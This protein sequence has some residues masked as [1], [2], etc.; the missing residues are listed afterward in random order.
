MDDI[1]IIPRDPRTQDIKI[2]SRLPKGGERGERGLPGP[3]GPQGPPGQDGQD[4]PAGPQGPPGQDGQ[5]G[6]TGPQGPPGQDGQDGATG[7]QGPPGADGQDGAQGP[8]G[9]PGADGQDGATGPQG[10]PGADGQD[11]AQGPQGEQGPPGGN[12]TS[13]GPY[14]GPANV[15]ILG[16]NRLILIDPLN[17]LVTLNFPP[18]ADGDVLEVKAISTGTFPGTNVLIVTNGTDNIEDP[19]LPGTALG[20]LTQ[21]NFVGGILNEA[22]R[23][24]FTDKI[25]TSG[26][27]VVTADYEPP[28]A[29]GGGL[30]SQPTVIG[31]NTATYLQ[32]NILVPIDPENGVVTL[33]FP[34]GNDGDI[35]KVTAV[36]D[37][38][39]PGTNVVINTDGT[40]AISN[41]LTPS[42]PISSSLVA[43]FAGGILKEGYE[44]VFAATVGANGTW[45]ATSDYEPA[46]TIPNQSF[47]IT[48]EYVVEDGY[49]VTPDQVISV[50]PTSGNVIPGYTFGGST[51][52]PSDLSDL[53]RYFT[54]DPVNNIAVG[55]TGEYSVLI[56]MNSD[57]VTRPI[58]GTPWLFT[59]LNAGDRAVDGLALSNDT[60]VI[61]FIDSNS[62]NYRAVSIRTN[63]G[64]ITHP[65]N[66]QSTP[67]AV[68]TTGSVI[69]TGP[70]TLS[71]GAIPNSGEFVMGFTTNGSPNGGRDFVMQRFTSAV[72]PTPP[73]LNSFPSQVVFTT[74]GGSTF[75]RGEAIF[76]PSDK[77][78][79]LLR[80]RDGATTEIFYVQRIASTFTLLDTQSVDFTA[81]AEFSRLLAVSSGIAVVVGN[82]SGRYKTYD[83]AG[84]VLTEAVVQDPIFNLPLGD[85]LT[86]SVDISFLRGT[87]N[88]VAV[89]TINDNTAGIVY[90]AVSGTSVNWGTPI[91]NDLPKVDYPAYV[92]EDTVAMSVQ[93]V[94][95]NGADIYGLANV[96]VNTG[97]SEVSMFR[98]EG[99]YPIGISTQAGAAGDTIIATVFGIHETTTALIPGQMY[100]ADVDGTIR[101]VPINTNVQFKTPAKLGLALTT[102]K[103]RI[104]LPAVQGVDF[105]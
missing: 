29:G 98:F 45:L 52:I 68:D 76:N 97:T 99:P 31:P 47:S 94:N 42:A 83:T 44:W 79:I 81:P 78:V 91:Y 49:S 101:R 54:L 22:Y 100:F 7:P 43:N 86:G 13:F 18:G 20:T 84:D 26:T 104:M 85:T 36:S 69:S 38:V 103:I 39:F 41:P 33:N 67:L 73:I 23:W 72:V 64:T 14:T 40:Q 10:P 60:Y 3:A 96:L 95:S 1:V 15:A 59:G 80:N 56:Q 34:T 88:L 74:A 28:Q 4:G 37:G 2:A 6:A 66:A 61:T 70:K 21:A 90:G 8:Q 12:L 51:N 53:R 92:S 75:D 30:V 62:S 89:G 16:V 9:P 57:G 82:D 63:T 5:D 46:A 32:G 25:G 19:A 93:F 24:E 17:D 11:G 77:I 50:D 71:L 55:F 102:N 65:P 48:Q 58:F 35:V 87:P 27:W 105:S